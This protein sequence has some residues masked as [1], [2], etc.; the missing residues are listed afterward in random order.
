MTR[1]KLALLIAVF[2]L[3]TLFS[4]SSVYFTQQTPT[5]EAEVTTLLTYQHDGQYDYIAQLASNNLYNKTTLKPGEGILYTDITDGINVTFTY[6]FNCS[7]P[8]NMTVQ[9]VEDEFMQS[10]NWNKT[11]SASPPET[12]NFSETSTAQFSLAQ[13][14]NVTALDELKSSIDQETGAPTSEFSLVIQPEIQ[15]TANTTVGTINE[16]FTPN[17][18]M[19]FQYGTP[20]GDYIDIEGLTNTQQGSIQKTETVYQPDVIDQRYLSYALSV[21]F[22][23]A[24][25]STTWA[26]VKAKPEGPEGAGKPI[27]EIIAPHEELIF[28]LAHAPSHE[29]PGITTVKM[30]SLDDLVSIADGLAKPILYLKKT[31]SSVFAEAVHVFYV[32][33]GSV[34]YEYEIS[35]P[36]TETVGTQ[37]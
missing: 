34:R 20:Q 32:L 29:T 8:A 31:P 17:M 23:S 21:I 28:N 9:Y 30:K 27:E 33:D 22:I 1:T 5:E 10:S 12:L 25:L 26:Y 18:T 3:L 7:F 15:V 4:L 2:A 35:G 11:I 16:P 14:I 36:K 37:G 24:L 13:S 19:T 6:T